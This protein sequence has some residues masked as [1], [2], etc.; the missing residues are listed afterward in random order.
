MTIRT[1]N[2]RT[3]AYRT[4]RQGDRFVTRYLASG[5]T[6]TILGHVAARERGLRDRERAERRRLEAIDRER[7]ARFDLVETLLRLALERAGFHRHKRQ[8][9]KR[10]MSDTT[11][12]TVRHPYGTRTPP[13]PRDEILDVLTRAGR[14]D[15]SAMPRLIELFALDPEG[16]V[17][18]AAGDLAHLG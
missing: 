13:A 11:P 3:Y 15:Q 17:R 1:R 14:G 12:I 8:W 18:A 16:M 2:G 6:A 10:R 5:T 7:A 4:I 9:R